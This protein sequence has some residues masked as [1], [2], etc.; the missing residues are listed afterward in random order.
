V[1]ELSFSYDK[2]TAILNELSFDVQPGQLAAFVGPSGAGKT[3]IFNLLEGFY[4]PTSGTIF[5]GDEKVDD[6]ALSTWRKQ[7]GYVSEK[8]EMIVGSNRNNLTYGLEDTDNITEE[9][10]WKDAKMV[11]ASQFI[12]E[13]EKEFDTEVGERGVKLSGGQRQRINIARAFLR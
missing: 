10:L 6:I 7:I 9:A 11:Y 13:F 4:Q 2:Q 3:T 5:I 8:S 12:R 1:E